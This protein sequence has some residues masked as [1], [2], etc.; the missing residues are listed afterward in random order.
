M[1]IVNQFFSIRSIVNFFGS[2]GYDAHFLP[3]TAYDDFIMFL[4]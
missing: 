2:L 3:I 1:T 4:R